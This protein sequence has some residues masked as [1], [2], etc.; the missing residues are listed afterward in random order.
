[1]KFFTARTLPI[2]EQCFGQN[3]EFFNSLLVYL[4]QLS[5][6]LSQYGMGLPVSRGVDTQYRK[7]AVYGELR[8]ELGEMFRE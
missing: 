7:K 1:M 8:T 3:K 5:E 6:C 2:F 4:P